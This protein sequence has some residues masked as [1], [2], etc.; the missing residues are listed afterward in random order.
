MLLLKETLVQSLFL[1]LNSLLGG[2]LDNF[3]GGRLSGLPGG[4][5]EGRLSGLLEGSLLGGLLCDLIGGRFLALDD[6][7]RGDLLGDPKGSRVVGVS[8]EVRF[9]VGIVD[10]VRVGI[11]VGVKVC[12]GVRVGESISDD[13]SVEVSIGSCKM[14]V[15]IGTRCLHLFFLRKVIKVLKFHS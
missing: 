11:V 5:L 4:L 15:I 8:I 7:F 10:G 14:G 12:I 9:G 6:H 1:E 2:L 3:L 13:V